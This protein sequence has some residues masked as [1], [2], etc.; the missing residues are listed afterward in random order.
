MRCSVVF[1]AFVTSILLFTSSAEAAACP[2]GTSFDGASEGGT[3]TFPKQVS[4]GRAGVQM[5]DLA[6][7]RS[8][9]ATLN[10]EY[11]YPNYRATKVTLSFAAVPGH[12]L[13]NPSSVTVPSASAK[14]TPNAATIPIRFAPDD[15]LGAVSV[16]WT[17]NLPSGECEIVSEY[18]QIAPAEPW[19]QFVSGSPRAGYWTDG[20]KL[21]EASFE[22]NTRQ[23]VGRITLRFTVGRRSKS[24]SSGPDCM[25]RKSSGHAFRGPKGL[26]IWV[27]DDNAFEIAFLNRR[28]ETRSVKYRISMNGEHQFSGRVVS[29][30][31]YHR[32]LR[33]YK[34]FETNYDEF[35]NL[36]I[37]SDRRLWAEGGRL[38]CWIEGTPSYWHSRVRFPE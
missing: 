27:S 3:L 8:A 28:R 7:G 9:S 35:V 34:V 24:I 38:Y 15:G 1:V 22:L 33:G 37:N 30:M 31:K 11:D 32:G 20:E 12:P 13:A 6:I 16:T 36:C 17:L 25:L 23:C 18:R 19:L 10:M 14:F 21:Q 29:T 26:R 2:T 4:E 5:N